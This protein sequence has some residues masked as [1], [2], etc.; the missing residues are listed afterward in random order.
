M[1]RLNILG[2]NADLMK[3][4]G[5]KTELN[6]GGEWYYNDAQSSASQ[7]SILDG[8]QTYATTRYPDG[9]SQMN[10]AGLYTRLKWN[11]SKRLL[12][13]PAVRLSYVSLDAK[14]NDAQFSP[15]FT[16]VSQRNLAANGQLG[17]VLN[18]PKGWRL[19]SAVSTGFRA[20]N[21]DDLGKTFESNAADGLT[22][23]NTSL[24]P[25]QTINADAGI[26]K[27]VA[28]RIRLELNG[29]YTWMFD[30]IRLFP[31]QFNG[32]DSVDFDG[33][34]AKVL[35]NT[36]T[37]RATVYGFYAGAEVLLGKYFSASGTINYT[38]GQD[39]SATVPL[40]HIPP[41]YGRVGLRAKNDDKKLA[42]E[43]FVLY[44]GWKRLSDYSPSGEDNLEYAIPAQ[45]MPAWYT[46]NLR[47]SYQLGRYLQAQLAVENILDTHYRVFSS[48]ISAPGRNFIFALRGNF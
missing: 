20:P 3:K 10:F 35:Q 31:A 14:T 37:A 36:N 38:I 39:I 44:N 23:P 13:I 6:Y 45:G 12:L 9:G 15:F 32:R 25:E 8:S 18:L 43:F 34:R 2:F 7:N 4:T 33:Q 41:V 42:G 48:G 47:G 26:E 17:G 11:V 27:N 46:L 28:G 24:R 22:I 29:F 19:T 40:D 1:E 21:V 30:A 5:A 16:S